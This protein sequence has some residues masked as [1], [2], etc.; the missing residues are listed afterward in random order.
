MSGRRPR[1]NFLEEYARRASKPPPRVPDEL[2]DGRKA[3]RL[4]RR[5]VLGNDDDAMEALNESHTWLKDLD[6]NT[7]LDKPAK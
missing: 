3:I 5:I 1:L 7:S 4:L 2:A 6:S